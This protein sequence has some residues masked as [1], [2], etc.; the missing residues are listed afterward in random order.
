MN[1][2]DTL[3]SKE[4]PELLQYTTKIDYG[5]A[6]PRKLKDII[7]IDKVNFLTINHK[8]IQL[9]AQ[10][11]KNKEDYDTMFHTRMKTVGKEK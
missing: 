11:P 6:V 10:I 3:D 8:V 2:K 7:C 9:E 4:K 5:H 1:E